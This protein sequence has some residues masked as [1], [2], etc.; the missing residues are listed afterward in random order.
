MILQLW[1]KEVENA[2]MAT[3]IATAESILG[4]A[5]H[6]SDQILKGMGYKNF[7]KFRTATGMSIAEAG[8]VFNMPLRTLQRRKAEGCLNPEESDRVYRAARVFSEIVDHN[9]GDEAAARVWIREENPRLGGKQ[10]FLMLGTEIGTRKVSQLI[11]RLEH[12][13]ET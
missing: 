3:I 12:F 1:R 7:E 11:G 10:P 4:I 8:Q 2:N 6:R 13:V 9:E 5:P